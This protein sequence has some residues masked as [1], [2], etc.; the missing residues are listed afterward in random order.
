MSYSHILYLIQYC[1]VEYFDYIRFAD[2]NW[3]TDMFGLMSIILLFITYLTYPFSTIPVF[4]FLPSFDKGQIFPLLQA[5]KSSFSV[6]SI[7][8][9]VE[10]KKNLYFSAILSVA[11]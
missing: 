10:E 4:V 2:F 8:K 7:M 9:T 11:S 3:F 6:V 5:L 1:Q